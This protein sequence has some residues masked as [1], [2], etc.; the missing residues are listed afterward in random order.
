MKPKY[1]SIPLAIA[2]VCSATAMLPSGEEFLMT[3]Q[4]IDGGGAMFATGSQFELSGT[5]GQPDAGTMSGD[6]F[7]LTGGFWFPVERGDG[8][9][10]G[11]IDLA[12]FDVF[13]RC[14]LGPVA[15]LG[16]GCNHYD[17]DESSHIDMRDF[18]AFQSSFTGGP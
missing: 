4:T 16:T 3:R 12:D 17:S 1:L 2:M 7:T 14:L 10:D 18:A 15:G 9:E 13:N 11:T 5:I 6:E 8:N